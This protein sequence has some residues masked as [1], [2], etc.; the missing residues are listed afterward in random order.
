LLRHLTF[1]LPSG[2]SVAK[3]MKRPVLDAVH[4]DDLKPLNLHNRT[5]LWFYILREADVEED[6]SSW[7]RSAAASSPK[8]S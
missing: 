8:C 6:G 2:Q 4:L 1:G 3:V 5:P 7:A